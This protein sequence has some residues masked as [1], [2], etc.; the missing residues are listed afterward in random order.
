VTQHGQPKVKVHEVG[1]RL[2]HPIY[3]LNQSE[4]ELEVEVVNFGAYEE[5]VSLKIA[6]SLSGRAILN[7][8]RFFFLEPASKTSF[9][10]PV[11]VSVGRACGQ[12]SVR[13]R[14]ISPEKD[15]VASNNEVEANILI[16]PKLVRSGVSPN[17]AILTP[18][19]IDSFTAPLI[20]LYP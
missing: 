4:V 6:A 17:F 13:F 18:Q 14:V 10:Q 9:Q 19:R 11:N 1:V 7:E 20:A 3:A 12:L 2:K 5:N 8:T 16:L 15:S